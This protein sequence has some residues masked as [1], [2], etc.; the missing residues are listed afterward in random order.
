MK[1]GMEIVRFTFMEVVQM[2]VFQVMC[3]VALLLPVVA[4]VFSSLFM[5][6]IAKVQIDV[7]AAGARALATAYVLFIAVTMFGRDIGEKFCHLLLTPPLTRYAYIT[8]RFLGLFAGL[9]LLML[10][11]MVSGEVMVLAALHYQSPVYRV[12]LDWS[13]G[14]AV[15]AAVFY[16]HVSLLAAATLICTYATGFA[17]MLVFTAAFAL[18]AWI[19]PPV[20]QALQ[21]Q[22]VLR[23]VPPAV[24][25]LAHAVSA[26]FPPLNGGDIAL[27]IAHGATLPA[28]GI[29]WYVI[30]HTGYAILMLG[31]AWLVFARRDL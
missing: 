26:L 7:L 5:L 12:G 18:F 19:L 21:S 16:E 4:W 10:I 27:A 24:A 28:H 11:V 15:A 3:A 17:E 25:S 23:H 14:I 20:L 8:G 22:E 30:G 29:I 6:D 1:S 13:T 9:M 31:A 2:R